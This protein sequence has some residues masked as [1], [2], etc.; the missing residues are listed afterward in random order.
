VCVC[1]RDQAMLLRFIYDYQQIDHDKTSP[2][3]DTNT[4]TFKCL[5]Y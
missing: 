4:L 5:A 1:D 2:D 3:A